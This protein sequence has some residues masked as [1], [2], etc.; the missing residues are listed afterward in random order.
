MH[1]VGVRRDGEVG[2]VV[3]EEE[4]AVRG[5]ARPGVARGGEHLVV[6]GALVAQLDDV[7]PAAQRRLEDVAQ[8]APAGT[9]VADEVQAG[10][11]EALAAGV[12]RRRLSQA[13]RAPCRRRVLQSFPTGARRTG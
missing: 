7:D 4:G 11:G 12:H 6:A 8:R 13:P 3:D 1:A 10:G 9:A 2:T 5:A